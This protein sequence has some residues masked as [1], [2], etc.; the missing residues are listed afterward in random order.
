LTYSNLLR[1]RR[2][3]V[4]IENRCYAG[5]DWTSQLPILPRNTGKE[6]HQKNEHCPPLVQD[7]EN[8][9]KIL[10]SQVLEEMWIR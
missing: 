3:I 1:R 9:Y 10:K 2:E 5:D 8:H 7:P 4:V 6:S